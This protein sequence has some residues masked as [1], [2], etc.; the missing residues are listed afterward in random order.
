MAE[1]F[2]LEFGFREG[3]AMR[4]AEGAFLRNDADKKVRRL[5]G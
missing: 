4:D 3:G 5:R 2:A 1:E